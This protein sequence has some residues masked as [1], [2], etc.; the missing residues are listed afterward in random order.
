MP[1]GAT[2]LRCI[3]KCQQSI[4]QTDKSAHYQNNSDI[5]N[6]PSLIQ[7]I[8]S[9]L[10][11]H[12]ISI[13]TL[14]DFTADREFHPALKTF[15]LFSCCSL[16]QIYFPSMSIEILNFDKIWA[17]KIFLCQF[18]KIG[19]NSVVEIKKFFELFFSKLRQNRPVRCCRQ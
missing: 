5:S 9:V 7:T 16:L 2:I 12:Q 1:L 3:E 6:T 13:C 11:F 15:I 14:A 8:L 10:D 17:A 19:H 4:L 18:G